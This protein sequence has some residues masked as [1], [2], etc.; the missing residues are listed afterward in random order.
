MITLS[1]VKYVTKTSSLVKNRYNSKTYD[2][3]VV[4][5]KKGRKAKIT[6]HAKLHGK[7]LNAYINGLIENDMQSLYPNNGPSLP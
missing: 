4:S 7:S 6:D 1:M 2:R 3:I 5:V